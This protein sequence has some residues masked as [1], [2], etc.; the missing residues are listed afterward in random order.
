MKHATNYYKHTPGFSMIN[1]TWTPWSSV[2]WEFILSVIW[3]RNASSL[4]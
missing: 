1:T 2:C 4:A 3:E